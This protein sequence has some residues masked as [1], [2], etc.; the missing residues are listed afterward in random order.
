MAVRTT[1]DIPEPIHDHLR[2]RAERSG[3]SIRSLVIAALEQ[4]YGL[5]SKGHR[6][7]GPLVKNSGKLGPA[8]P[9]DENPYDFFL[10]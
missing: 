1:I 8:F 5:G 6:V 10:P 4:A 2:R 3:V 9:V 7:T